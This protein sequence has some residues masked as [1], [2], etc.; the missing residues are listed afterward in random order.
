VLQSALSDP[1]SNIRQAGLAAA[2]PTDL[3]FLRYLDSTETV[4]IA[5]IKCKQHSIKLSGEKLS[6]LL[7]V[8]QRLDS[9]AKLQVL[10]LLYEQ[11]SCS[12]GNVPLLPKE[13]E[14]LLGILDQ[15]CRQLN[16]IAVFVLSIKCVLL[17]LEQ[18]PSER[19][20]ALGRDR[21]KNLRQTA[22]ENASPERQVLID[23]ELKAILF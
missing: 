21:L 18:V 1:C 6:Q 20:R 17:L 11:L 4:S 3:D 13:L 22:I 10:S 5:L 2:G 23:K 15:T 14:R 7:L 8:L 16:S 19:A 12:V 9:R